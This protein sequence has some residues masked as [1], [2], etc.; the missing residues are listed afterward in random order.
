R[1]SMSK[2]LKKSLTPT[3]AYAAQHQRRHKTTS[4][5]R[6]SIVVI[7]HRRESAIVFFLFFVDHNR[8]GIRG[9]LRS[10]GEGVESGSGNQ[11]LSRG[12]SGHKEREGDTGNTNYF[13]QQ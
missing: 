3:K 6:N 10:T 8:A 13:T 5:G 11:D 4:Q 7:L 2:L 1:E 9:R 12:A